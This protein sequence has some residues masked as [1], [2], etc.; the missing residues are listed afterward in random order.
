MLAEHHRVDNMWDIC[1]DAPRCPKFCRRLDVD[2]ILY[3]GWRQRLPD[4]RDFLIVV[5]LLLLPVI[6]FSELFLS[7]K[8]LFRSDISRIHYPLAVLKARSFSSGQVPVWNPYILFGFP[9]LADQDVLALHPLNLFFLFPLKPH[10]ALSYFVVAHFILAG[11]FS[12]LMARSLQMSRVG[13][14]ITAVTFA[15][16]GY[17]MAQLSNLPIMTGSAWFPLTFF[18]FVKTLQTMRPT[19]AVLCG[20]AIALQILASHPQ[21][22]FYSLLILG[23]YGVFRFI[24]LWRG[25]EIGIQDKRKT[26]IRLVALLALAVLVGLALAAIQIAP[27]WEMKGLSPRAT[28]VSYQTMTSYSLPPHNLLTF[29]FPNI[30]G[31]PVI[32]YTGQMHFQ[33]L[34]VYVGILPLLLIPWAWARRKRDGHVAFFTILA[35]GSL[36][37]AL[38]RHT[39]LYHLLVY[40]PGFNFFR[41]PARWL[42]VA[43]IS[44][45]VLAGYGYDTLAGGHDRVESR[46]FAILWKTLGWLNVGLTL[47]LLAGLACGEQVIQPLNYLP[48]GLLSEQ[49]IERIRSLIHGLTRLPL[50][51]L[52]DNLSATLSSLNPALLFILL[53]NA[54]FLLICIWNKR[55]IAAT[56]FQVMLVSLIVVDL[57]L[58]AGTT[59]NPVRDASYFERQVGSTTFLQQNSGLYRIYSAASGGRVQSLSADMP[60][61]YELYGAQ[62]HLSELVGQRTRNFLEIL[63]QR[64]ALV[65]LAGVKYTLV[66]KGSGPPGTVR[67]YAGSNLEIYENESVLP[68]AFIVHHVEVIP[69]EQAVLDSLLS[70]DF[71]PGHTVLLEEEPSPGLDQ[72]IVP[73]ESDLHEAE[74][75]FY[76][77]QRVVVEA[78]LKVDGF[79][80]LS[81]TYYPGWKVFVDGR[82]DKI[83]QADY[84][85]R[86]VLLRQGKHV[87]E[88]RYSPLS[89]RVGLAISLATGAILCGMA[90]YSS[91]IRRRQRR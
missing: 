18:L 38:G 21:V 13:A 26:A 28:G 35:A 43:T 57:L 33:E 4:K 24:R 17:L 2:R 89:F 61:V 39:P 88:F 40:V 72:A 56:A 16:S 62:G 67:V 48:N 91:L 8:T 7:D 75:T 83:Y 79:L 23:S 82:E 3:M 12:Y 42:F 53:S 78:D 14:F 86:A 10:V 37:L 9:Q 46:R 30:L 27:T 74:I 25:D 36:L 71:D 11:I 70:D 20:G 22:V 55:R 54:G 80:V 47:I 1:Y 29:L 49:S 58:T 59:I 31:N 44:F 63:G 69:S 34:H 51:Q 76:S 87:V 77:P 66:E 52:S 6:S 85:F 73:S 15:L 50:I 41:V 64:A 81:D 65:N 5:L 68:R 60:T 19:Y 90:V 45:S 32:G 84:L